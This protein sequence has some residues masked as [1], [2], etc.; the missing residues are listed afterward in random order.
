[1]GERR[2]DATE[3]AGTGASPFRCG[4]VA[5]I[6]R[7]NSGKSTLLNTVL[8]QELS[9]VSSLPQTTRRNLRGILTTDSLQIVF[10]DTP[11]I[12]DG[13]HRYNKAM[14][15]ESRGVLRDKGIDLIAYLVDLG[16]EFGAEE[17][18]VAG[19]VRAASASV[20]V[21]FNKV[22]RCADVGARVRA[23]FERYPALAGR[24]FVRIQANKRDAREAFVAAVAPLLPEGPALFP[25]DELTDENMRF[26]A[27]EYVRKGIIACTREEVPHACAVEILAYEE[28]ATRHLVDAVIH[29]ETD[30]Q[31]GI[32]I[33]KG[34]GMLGRIRN[35]AEVDMSRLAGLPVRYRMHVKVSA[36]WRDKPGFLR[37]MG[38]R[39]A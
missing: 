13:G 37:E 6:G 12:H 23:F 5:L 20:L 25:A 32:L 9:V 27:A 22:D 11:G 1:M 35:L 24:R 34:G 14:S 39:D 31:R 17:D 19:I 15:A 28:G 8:G 16:R 36:G 18:T 30:G 10:V 29:V 7:P 21:V 33:G 26:F 4:M 2:K 38:Y 3:S